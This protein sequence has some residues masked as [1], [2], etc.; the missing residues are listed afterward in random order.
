MGG[1]LFDD[2][3]SQASF[4]SESVAAMEITEG[5]TWDFH[6]VLFTKILDVGCKGAVL[7]QTIENPRLTGAT[8]EH[9]PENQA[10]F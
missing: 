10:F 3:S 2:S 7:L 1:L 6:I 4:K 8:L 9:Y 5:L